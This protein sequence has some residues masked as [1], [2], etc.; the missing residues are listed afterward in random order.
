MLWVKWVHGKY[1]KQ[2]DWWDYQAPFDCS[3][4]WKK[5][6]KNKELFKQGISQKASWAWQDKPIYTIRDGY[7]WLPGVLEPRTGAR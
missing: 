2:Q 4:Y 7:H 5:I 1:L 6:M 3:W